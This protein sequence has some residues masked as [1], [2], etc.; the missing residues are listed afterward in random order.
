M[1]RAPER[2]RRH[3]FVKRV[4]SRIIRR[5]IVKTT[6]Q[7]CSTGFIHKYL[8]LFQLPKLIAENLI[9]SLRMNATITTRTPVSR[10]SLSARM[11]SIFASRNASMTGS[12]NVAAFVIILYE[13]LNKLFSCGE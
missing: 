7:A 12:A 11:P 5:G 4:A 2:G 8:P 9:I 3:K 13:E 6:R 1:T 10:C